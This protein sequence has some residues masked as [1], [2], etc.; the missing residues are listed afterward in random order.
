[1]ND[2]QALIR[3][4]KGD[5]KAFETIL[6]AYEKRVFALAFSYLHNSEDAKDIAQEV[7]FRAYKYLKSFN[8]EKDFF[9]WLYSIEL[10][11][12]RNH[13][14][15]KKD[16]RETCSGDILENVIYLDEG[17][18]SAD[19]KIVFFKALDEL[20]EDDKHFLVLRYIMALEIKEIAALKNKNENQ[21]RVGIFR[22]KDR[23]KQKLQEEGL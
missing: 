10:N 12:I 20:N 23:L 22:A 14:N 17:L 16:N 7:F 5:I 19:D 8:E 1:M 6:K 11:L 15:H 9:P 3:A 13:I 4:K 2:C 21:V 18:L